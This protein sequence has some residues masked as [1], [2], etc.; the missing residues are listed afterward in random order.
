M[1]RHGVSVYRR[2]SDGKYHFCDPR[3]NYSRDTTFVLR[4]EADKGHRVWE[5]L[6]AGIDHYDREALERELA[7]TSRNRMNSSL[8]RSRCSRPW[9]RLG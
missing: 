7:L 2:D 3:G 6:P 1:A 9:P 5:T 8:L 4:Y